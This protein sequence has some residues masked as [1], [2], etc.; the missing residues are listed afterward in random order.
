MKLTALEIKQQQFDKSLRGFDTAEVQAF[1]NLMSNEWEHMVSKNRELQEKIDDMQEKLKH[2]ERVE[3]A[4]HETLQAA[5]ESAE[6]KLTGARKEAENKI[7]KAE[8]QAE[9]VIKE[10][11]QEKQQERQSILRLLDRR[12]EIIGGI[13]SYLEVAQE[14][15][16]Q[17]SKDKA[18]LF[19]RPAELEN[20][21]SDE[22]QAP[23]STENKPSQKQK[24]SAAARTAP[25]AHPSP[26]GT[27][28]IDDLVDDLE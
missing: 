25:K 20:Q 3:E 27:E 13:R 16:E 22:E 17:F 14:S 1:L 8:M 12:K 7:E 18:R 24:K 26:P 15:I 19:D 11:H 6:T 21:F 5:K 28:D 23:P 4:L 9:A 10:A 2:Y